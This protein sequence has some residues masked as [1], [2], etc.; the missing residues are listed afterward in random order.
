LTMLGNSGTAGRLEPAPARIDPVQK[1]TGRPTMT[2]IGAKHGDG[3]FIVTI[4]T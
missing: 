2:T 1:M 3:D 4:L